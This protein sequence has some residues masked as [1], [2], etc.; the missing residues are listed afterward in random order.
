MYDCK[1]TVVLDDETN[2]KSGD[3]V[4]ALTEKSSVDRTI[5]A[6]SKKKK[7][8]LR[9]MAARASRARDKARVATYAGSSGLSANDG[10]GIDQGDWILD[11]DASRHFVNEESMLID[12]TTCA[13]EI[14]MADGESLRL[15]RVGSVRLEVLARGVKMTVT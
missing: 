12:S 4:L 11:S 14:I 5:R 2:N 10:I 15:T 9:G 3:M 13:H 7:K 1:A 6:K 8:A